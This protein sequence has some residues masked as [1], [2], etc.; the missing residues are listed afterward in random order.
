MEDKMTRRE[1]LRGMFLAGMGLAFCGPMLCDA[2]R[3]AN[4]PGAP[5]G[6]PG[7]WKEAPAGTKIDTRTWN[8]MGETLGMLGCS[9]SAACACP[10]WAAV[11][12][13]SAATRPWT[14]KPSTRWWTTPSPTA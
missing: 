11:A 6:L 13:V 12:A 7:P 4:R 3:A 10:R 5:A 1:A 9:A 8:K 2:A 14:R